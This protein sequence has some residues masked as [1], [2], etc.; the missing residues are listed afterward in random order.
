M[1]AILI[2]SALCSLLA[3]AGLT[4]AFADQG[5]PGWMYTAVLVLALLQALGGALIALGQRRAGARLAFVAAIPLVPLGL[6]ALLGARRV[7]DDLALHT[8]R[9][10]R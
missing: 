2:G 7:L 1:L 5:L 3:L 9:A 6:I 10:G 8:F 4:G